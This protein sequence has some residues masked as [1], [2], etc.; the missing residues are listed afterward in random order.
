MPTKVVY[1]ECSEVVSILTALI[2]NG[3]GTETPVD[4]REG[5]HTLHLEGGWGDHFPGD[6]EKFEIVICEDCLRKW[7]S[8]FKHQDVT[9][10]RWPGGDPYTVRHSE[11][12]EEMTVDGPW[13]L[14]AGVPY[15]AG[16][17]ENDLLPLPD[18]CPRNGS[19]WE[20]FKGRRYQVFDY[21]FHVETG[22][23]F[24]I[25][26]PLYGESLLWARPMSMWHDEVD[27]PEIPYKGP[28]FRLILTIREAP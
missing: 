24:T 13:L 20:H 26:R 14:P 28:R 19:L 16:R 9:I 15:P 10:Y 7:V 27:R 12:H 25:Y 3:C 5:F 11:T 17:T 21:A 8:T 18:T 1:R 23:P 6:T 4:H 2:C 22:E